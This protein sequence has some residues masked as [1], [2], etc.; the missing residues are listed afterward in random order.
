VLLILHVSEP[1]AIIPPALC[2]ALLMQSAFVLAGYC[3]L[4]I[5][6]RRNLYASFLKCMG[7]EVPKDLDLSIDGI[8][9][10]GH[11]IAERPSSTTV[12]LLLLLVL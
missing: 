1:H 9:S 5:R 3:F 8:V 12:S 11:V 6:V 10:S 2:L 4:N 7:R